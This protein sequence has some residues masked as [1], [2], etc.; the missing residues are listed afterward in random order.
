MELSFSEKESS[1]GSP[2]SEQTNGISGVEILYGHRL[3][4]TEDADAIFFLKDGKDLDIFRKLIEK[5]Y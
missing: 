1:V 3:S 2:A 5:A 4:A